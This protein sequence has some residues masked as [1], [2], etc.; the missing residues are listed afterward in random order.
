MSLFRRVAVVF[1]L[2]AVL[3]VSALSPAFGQPTTITFLSYGA[4]GEVEIQKKLVEAFEQTHPDI[5][6]EEIY[7]SG[8]IAG[9]EAKFQ[10]MMAAGTPPDVVHENNTKLFT[11]ANQGLV[12]DMSALIRKDNQANME[13]FY[14]PTLT[15]VTLNNRIYGLPLFT[16]PSAVFI[17][18]A[19]FQEA[20]VTY[21]PDWTFNDLQNIAQKLTRDTNNDG[22]P[23]IWG[24]TAISTWIRPM[25]WAWAMGGDFY[26]LDDNANVVP[27]FTNPKYI[28]GN[29]AA[30]RLW[31]DMAYNRPVMGGTF[32]LGNV[33]MDTVTWSGTTWSNFKAA[34]TSI[35]LQWN[36]GHMPT[37]P[38]GYKAGTFAF[39][40]VYLPTGSHKQDAAYRFASWLAGREGQRLMQV[41][42]AYGGVPS[43]RSV[44]ISAGYLNLDPRIKNIVET[45]AYMRP[46]PY[47][48]QHT[49]VESEINKR[50]SPL[51]TGKISPMAFLQELQEAVGAI[52]AQR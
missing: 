4:A 28:E 25:G 18:E 52:A 23:D 34:Q 26:G 8:G 48:T 32:R 37:G 45:A 24:H 41:E 15:G 11:F 33:G 51:T 19:L 2:T 16:A 21:H 27:N 47:S 38:Y 13:D 49:Q 39:N 10:T 12:Q 31:Q 46:N 7:A 44:A 29:L 20:G 3:S 17:N 40:V 42:M 30:I 50:M 35:N 6:I 14:P 5:K 22:K 9:V 36:I 1:I 43:R